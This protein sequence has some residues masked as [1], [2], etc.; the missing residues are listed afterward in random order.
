MTRD[1]EALAVAALLYRVGRFA[2]RL[3][4]VVVVVWAAALGGVFA[5]ASHAAPAPPDNNSIPGAKFQKANDLLQRAFHANPNGATAQIV[6]VAPRGQKITAARYQPVISKVVAEAARSPQVQSAQT[7]SQDGE[8]S[9]DGS[10]AIGEIS[11]TAVQDK[12]TTATT[13]TLKDAAH[14]G[15]DAGLTVEVGGDALNTPFSDTAAIYG[16][17]V[18]LVVLLV[19]FGSLAAA[20]LPLLT[21]GIGVALGL[22]G[23]SA[24]AATLGL[25]GTTQSLALMLGLAVSID[26]A[27][28]IISRYRLQA[29]HLSVDAVDGRAVLVRQPGGGHPKRRTVLSAGPIRA[30]KTPSVAAC[31]ASGFGTG[32]W[33]GCRS[34]TLVAVSPNRRHTPASSA[35]ATPE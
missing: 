23:I 4:W 32:E 6:F 16:L 28:F 30:F 17:A 21:A 14:L 25:S 34:R 29:R 22:L 11:Y 9:R 12:L 1:S 3:R 19:T 33:I 27:L 7:P 8:V 35:W 18:A 5:A 20:G 10:T 24:L 15:R 13:N 2:F 26:Y 31:E